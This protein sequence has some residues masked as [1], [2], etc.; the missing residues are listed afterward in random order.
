MIA[1]P[2]GAKVWLAGGA[3]DMRKG[4][5]GLALLVQQGLGREAIQAFHR[6]L[7]ESD[8]LA[9]LTMMA[10]RLV[11]LHRVLS[12]TGSLYLH[13]DPTASHYLKIVLRF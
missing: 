9:Y 13:C 5:N 10:A 12:R 11:E 6:L 8:M 3:T 2:P 4:M 1:F 7:G